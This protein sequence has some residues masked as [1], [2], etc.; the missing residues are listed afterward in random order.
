MDPDPRRESEAADKEAHKRASDVLS[1]F[2]AAEILDDPDDLDSD[3]EHKPAAQ[4]DTPNP[5]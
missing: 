2:N 1:G 5:I 3:H 4:P